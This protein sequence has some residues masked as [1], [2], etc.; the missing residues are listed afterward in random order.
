MIP[1]LSLLPRAHE[2]SSPKWTNYPMRMSFASIFSLLLCLVGCKSK[3]A[4]SP[5]PAPTNTKGNTTVVYECNER[6]FARENAFQTIQDYLPTLA[7]MQVNVLWLMPIHPRGTV[8]TVNSPYCVKDYK[9]IDPAFG[10]LTDLQTLVNTCHTRGI[11]VILDWPANHTAWDNAWYLEH[12]DWYTTPTQEEA[13]WK[14]VVPLDYTKQAVR[15]AM[16]DAMLYWVEEAD[17]DGFRCDYAHGVPTD[18]WKSAIDAIRAVKPDAILLAETAKT[19]Y[20]AAGFD[21]LYSWDYLASI[22]KTYQSTP[23]LTALYKTNQSELSTTPSGK[24]RLRYTTTH[25]ASAEN[26]PAT[27][28]RTAAGELSAACLTFFL[29]GIPMI[30]SSQEIGDMEK[31][32]F[33]NYDLKS[34]S[35]SNATC[36]AYIA[37]MKAYIATAEARYGSV[38]DH[39]SDHIAMFSRTNGEKAILVI[40]NTTNQEQSITLP[41]RW[42]RNTYTNALTGDSVTSPRTQTLQPYEYIIY[43]N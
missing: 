32:N 30:Y 43:S 14:D 36:Q 27:F 6:L 3:E 28:Y 12:P 34:F 2:V 5:T 9:A 15:D 7:E 39:S 18:F 41:M 38:E 8:N 11:R 37:L 42:Q 19:E 31:I 29:E 17:I 40:V 13:G 10:T 1:F 25:D 24:Y 35:S 20:Y 4:P 22:Q 26:A 23:A 21:W 16:L 33:F